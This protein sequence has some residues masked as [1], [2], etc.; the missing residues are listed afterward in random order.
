MFLRVETEDASGDR[1]LREKATAF[2]VQVPVTDKVV[3]P[4]LVTAAHVIQ[5]A[6]ALSKPLL[7]R[8]NVD[9]KWKDKEIPADAWLEHLSSDVAVADARPVLRNGWDQVDAI[10]RELLVDD[11]TAAKF[12]IG[13]GDEVF[14]P[15]LFTSVP[16]ETRDEPIVRFG[17]IALGL[18]ESLALEMPSGRSKTAGYLIEARSWG[19]H[20]GSPVFVSFMGAQGFAPEREGMASLLGLIHGHY[21]LEAKVK[22]NDKPTEKVVAPVNAGIAV[23]MP[24]QAIIDL[25]E[26]DEFVNSRD[27]ERQRIEAEETT[28][29]PDMA[30]TSDDEFDRFEDLTGKLLK[31]PKKELDEK[32]EEEKEE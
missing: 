23:V 31:V 19:G 24:A 4:Y 6:R 5:E 22:F 18:Q 26:E 30:G 16:G 9:D 10:P 7:A 32:R 21:E 17:H 2:V 11:A 25:L 27:E 28:P 20:S 29:V 8:V 14:M 12:D 1:E 15:G 3:V 13:E